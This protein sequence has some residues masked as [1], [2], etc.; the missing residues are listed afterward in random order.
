MIVLPARTTS[1]AAVARKTI[2]EA[3]RAWAPSQ[4][5][6]SKC[7]AAPLSGRRNKEIPPAGAGGAARTSGSWSRGSRRARYGRLLE[8]KTLMS[9]V[10]L[11][12]ARGMKTTPPRGVRGEEEPE[13]YDT[14]SDSNNDSDG[15]SLDGRSWRRRERRRR[16][17]RFADDFSAGHASQRGGKGRDRISGGNS[18]R[19]SG[20]G[21]G[22]SGRDAAG[23]EGSA[24]SRTEEVVELW[25]PGG[26]QGTIRGDNIAGF[27]DTVGGDRLGQKA[28][29]AIKA[30]PGKATRNQQGTSGKERSKTE[31]SWLRVRA[32]SGAITLQVFRCSRRGSSRAGGKRGDQGSV[33]EGCQESTGNVRGR[34]DRR[35]RNRG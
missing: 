27:S 24:L 11:T 16:R 15:D 20:M 31:K 8:S 12:W 13:R 2:V 32:R 1:A 9:W 29:G 33:G 35:R 3:R 22:A 26:S 25:R 17:G 14:G 34:R 23:R 10:E 28:E 7:P 21:E 30:P 19:E 18:S 6:T 5:S 4:G